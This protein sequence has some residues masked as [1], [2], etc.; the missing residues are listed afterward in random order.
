M[1]DWHLTRRR[2]RILPH[3]YTRPSP[4]SVR[5]GKP[6]ISSRRC[7]W[8]L[9]VS[10]LAA[11]VFLG[12]VSGGSAQ[13]S[14]SVYLPVVQCASTPTAQPVV[15]PTATPFGVHEWRAV[16]VSRYDWTTYQVSVAPEDITEIVESAV[17]GG[18]NSIIFQVRGSGDAYY[19][20]GLE[21]WSARL[22]GTLCK[23][24]GQ[25]PGFDPLAMLV[26]QAHAAG[27]SVHAWV[28]VYPA[29]LAP[30]SSSREP[31]APPGD[32]WP[33][34]AFNRFTYSNAGAGD[35]SGYGLGWS[36]R[37]HD[38]DG[39]PMSLLGVGTLADPDYLWASPALSEWQD[40]V[41]DITTDIVARYDVDGVHLDNVRYPGSGYSLDPAT[42]AACEADPTCTDAA[43][44]AWRAPFQRAQ[45]TALVARITSEIHALRPD[46][47]VSAAVWP[48]HVDR[49]GWGNV[50]EGYGDYYQDSQGWLAEGQI[51]ATAP[52]LYW[53]ALT[54]ESGIERWSAA[55]ADHVSHANGGSVLAGI[56]VTEAGVR[57]SFD[58]ILARIET[59]RALGAAGQALFSLRALKENDGGL[60]YLDA[61]RSGPY[62]TPA[63]WP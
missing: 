16:W 42:L 49:W 56:G 39:T 61:L 26:S 46:C 40:Y 1:G 43:E 12:M 58:E 55:L 36:W 34:A 18:F 60:N 45:V 57:V 17:R 8:V 41:T 2:G 44:E 50:G 10:A 28:N 59:A 62:A 13:G 20:P 14:G 15:T 35:G 7:R 4:N 22:T 32:I 63:V 9:G 31:V 51:D 21:P 25:H 6:V 24:L 48:V 30:A 5:K 53:P 54:N 33:P 19:A 27:L 29:W 23:T 52:M 47:I 37:V 11:A 38:L 3:D